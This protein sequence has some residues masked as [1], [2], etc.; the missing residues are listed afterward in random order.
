MQSPY[1]AADEPPT[2]ATSYEANSPSV[3]TAAIGQAWEILRA[4][5]AT[6]IG[7]SVVY[8][9]VLGALYVV[10]SLLLVRDARGLPQQTPFSYFFLF[11]ISILSVFLGAGLFKVAI[12]QLRTGRAEFSEMFNIFDVAAPL[13]IAAVLVSLLTSIGLVFCIVPGVLVGLGLCMT[14][15]LIV[16]QKID[17]VEAMKRS[18]AVCSGHLGELLVLSLVLGVIMTLGLCACG[19]GFVVTVPLYYLTFAI[20]YRDLFMGGSFGAAASMPDFPTPPIANP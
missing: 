1:S 17:A 9:L 6:W 2:P 4:N 15:P 5:I 16:D 8:L 10:Q 7:I 19:L 3:S 11:L 20:V 14:T 18:W 12:A 13:F